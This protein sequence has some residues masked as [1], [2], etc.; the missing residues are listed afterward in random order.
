MHTGISGYGKTG[1]LISNS[2]TAK[3]AYKQSSIEYL[4]VSYVVDLNSL[5]VEHPSLSQK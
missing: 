3:P 1:I 4:F 5:L 2:I